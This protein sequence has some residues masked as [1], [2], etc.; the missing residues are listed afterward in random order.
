MS[1]TGKLMREG[2]FVYQLG[3]KELGNRFYFRVYA[4]SHEQISDEDL[5]RRLV[6]CWNACNGIPTESLEMG[7]LANLFNKLSQDCV[8]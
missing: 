5:A 1:H 8:D 4:H 3:T 2:P 6:A 7:E